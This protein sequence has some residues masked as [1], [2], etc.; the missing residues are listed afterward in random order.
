MLSPG[1]NIII[2]LSGGA[3]SVALLHVLLALQTELAIAQIFAVH[4]NHGIRADAAQHDENFVKTLCA[5]LQISLKIYHAN[6]PAIAQQKGLSIEET[7]RKMR[8]F[9]FNEA[10]NAFG[11]PTA[12]IATGHHQ[13]DNAETIIMNLARGAGLKGLCGI[14]PTNGN[15]IRPL[16]DVSRQDIE[17]Y[18]EENSLNYVTDASN[19]SQEYTRNRIRHRVLPAIETAINPGA[20]QTIAKNAAWLREDDA[21]IESAAAQAFQDCTA[22]SSVCAISLDAA[23]L[24]AL[25]LAIARRVIRM[26]VACIRRGKALTNI[27]STHIQTVLDLLPMKSGKEVH[28]PGLTA[29][30]EYACITIAIPTTPQ[31]FGTYPLSVPAT[32]NIPELNRTLSL[33]YTPPETLCVFGAKKMI[34]DCTKVFE[35][36]IVDE[37]LFLRTRCPGDKIILSGTKHGAKLFTKKLQDYFTDAK[38]PRHKRDFIPI[39]ACGSDVLWVLD[40]KGPT[41]E[42][43]S[44]KIGEAHYETPFWV[45]LWRDADE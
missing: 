12:K 7:G 31:K 21:Y 36:G 37:G 42:K 28:L 43:Y 23:K 11:V 22:A 25:P 38:I 34:L 29:R 4:I 26:A 3:D 39:L 33:S 14:P 18:L 44:P 6:I 20:V 17:N 2:G 24:C 5:T 19:H 15:I 13:N 30:K 40:E 41:S 16:L 27:S 10:C 9:H 8:Y 45:S 1:D 35:Y 32:I